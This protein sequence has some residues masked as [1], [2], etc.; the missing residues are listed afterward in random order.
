MEFKSDEEALRWYVWQ[1]RKEALFKIWWRTWNARILLWWYR[2]W[3]RQD[4]FHKSV[5]FDVKAYT[6]MDTT[7]RLVYELDIGKRRTIAH[8]RDIQ[9][10]DGEITRFA[11]VKFVLGDLFNLGRERRIYPIY[12]W[13]PIQQENY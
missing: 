2:L 1:R 10:T 7:G 5:S 13:P 4:E 8:E 12:Y 3:I 11:N 9:R 6:V